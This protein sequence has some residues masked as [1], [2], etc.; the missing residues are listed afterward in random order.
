VVDRRFDAV[1]GPPVT[2]LVRD[3][4]GGRLDVATAFGIDDVATRNGPTLAALRRNSR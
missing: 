4:G 2:T 3:D 1:A